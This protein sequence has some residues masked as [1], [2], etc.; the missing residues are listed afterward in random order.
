MGVQA[1]QCL[2]QQGGL[3]GV[4]AFLEGV[5]GRGTTEVFCRKNSGAIDGD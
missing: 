2:L 3:P 1:L 5:S 4:G